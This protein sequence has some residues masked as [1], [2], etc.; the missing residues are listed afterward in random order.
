MLRELHSADVP[1]QCFGVCNFSLCV[2]P[3]PTAL[4]T[5]I[6]GWRL[7]IWAPTL[8]YKPFSSPCLWYKWPFPWP[9]NPCFLGNKKKQGLERCD[10]KVL[11]QGPETPKVPK[12]VRRGCKRCFGPGGQRSPTSLLHHQ[13]PGLHPVRCNSLLHQC[14]RTLVPLAQATFCTLS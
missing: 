7:T 4:A 3:I 9:S 11:L 1:L 14:K 13:N 10:P 2:S 8:L 5:S 12:V 6:I